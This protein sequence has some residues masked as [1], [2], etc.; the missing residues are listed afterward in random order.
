MNPYKITKEVFK[1]ILGVKSLKGTYIEH[2]IKQVFGQG[3]Q[4]STLYKPRSGTV[5]SNLEL[6]SDA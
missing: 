5:N 3:S 1:L 6:Y 4:S 2:K